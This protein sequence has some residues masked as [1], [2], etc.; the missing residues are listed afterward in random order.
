MEI[1]VK[2][3]KDDQ[4]EYKPCQIGD[5]I[6]KYFGEQMVYVIPKQQPYQ[7]KMKEIWYK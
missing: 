5:P 4:P 7:K 2:K 6:K 3:E 1:V